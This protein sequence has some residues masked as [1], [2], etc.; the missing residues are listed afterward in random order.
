MN[1]KSIVIVGA[2]SDIA[3]AIIRELTNKLTL[4]FGGALNEYQYI[5][6]GRDREKLQSLS[7]DLA[8]RYT[9]ESLCYECDVCN[10]S[11]I[12]ECM[13]SLEESIFGVIYAAGFMPQANDF[14]TTLQTMQINL[15]SAIHIL[16]F[17]ATLLESKKQGFIIA[18]SSVAGDRGRASNAIYGSTKAGLSA[19]MSALSNRFGLIKDSKVRVLCVKPG[20]VDTK[21]TAHLSLPQALTHSPKNVAKD[22]IHAL[23][24]NKS[25]VYTKSLWRWI[26]LI[27]KLLPHRIF[28]KLKL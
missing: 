26:M 28:N 18:I 27:I 4:I 19:Y 12:D 3:K 22:I 10:Q 6:L 7:Q 13:Q 1:K 16:E 8:L 11:C 17:C 2:N 5:L 15:L 9:I 14:D 23:R 25:V 20:F 21:M 24:Q